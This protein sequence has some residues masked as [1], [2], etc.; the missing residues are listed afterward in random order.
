MRWSQALAAGV[1]DIAQGSP[2]KSFS[3]TSLRTGSA[4]IPLGDFFE[5]SAPDK[6][7]AAQ[8]VRIGEEL[9]IVA[10]SA[11]AMRGMGAHSG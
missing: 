9:E 11:E 10:L 5:G 4:R 3:P 7:L 1:C 8:V 6:P 2:V